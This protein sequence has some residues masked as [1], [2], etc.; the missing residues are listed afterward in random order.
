MVRAAGDTAPSTGENGSARA[1]R[2]G[3]RP[4]LDGVRAI[5]IV[6]VMA[7]HAE[8]SQA[9]G[10]FLGV[11]VF[12]VLSGFLITALLV[13]ERQTTGRL[14]L[15]H[16]YA[17]RGLRLLPALLIL[18]AAL[19]LYALL[20]PHHPEVQTYWR[21]A[22]S[23]LFYVQNWV[24][25]AGEFQIRLLA[26]TWSLSIEE[27]FYLL[28]PLVLLLLLRR[29]VRPAITIAVAL[30]GV[31]ASAAARYLLLHQ[32]PVHLQRVFNGLDTRGGALMTGCVLGLLV[33]W[34]LLPTGRWFRQAAA[35]GGAVGLL[36]LLWAMLGPR[37]DGAARILHPGR[38][39]EEGLPLVAVAT[40]LIILSVVVAHDGLLAR[41]LALA[42]LVWIGRVSYGL[43]LWHYPIDRIIHPDAHTFGLSG[44]GLQLLRLAATLAVVTLSFYLAERPVLR[45]KSRFEFR[46]PTQ[47]TAGYVQP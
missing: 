29:R 38:F 43:Y 31:L 47:E 34:R 25:A 8:L 5:A 9:P 7:F 2:L 16:F 21:D 6:A 20:D 22:L 17:R 11:D 40:G 42:P 44:A 12:F 19:G 30:G 45:Y 36:A 26:H 18:L 1:F 46:R 32:E 41:V 10:G 28:W 15:G 13:E 23:S 27:Q 39:Y 37:Y 4:P 33:G 3:A 14:H 35:V 24:A